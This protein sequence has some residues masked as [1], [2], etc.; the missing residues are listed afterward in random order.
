MTCA[1]CRA[2]MLK[3]RLYDLLENDG[4]AYVSG[5]GWVY[6]CVTC[7]KVSDWIIEQNRQIAA[8]A[9]TGDQRKMTVKNAVAGWHEQ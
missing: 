6:R 7:G 8:H 9:V 5:W 4:Q 3:E 1:R 2:V